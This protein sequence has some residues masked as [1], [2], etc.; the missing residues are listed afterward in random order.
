LEGKNN[1]TEINH[2]VRLAARVPEKQFAT[3]SPRIAP[4]RL[5]AAVH[6]IHS[7]QEKIMQEAL[8]C[9]WARE[10][11]LPV[12]IRRSLRELNHRFLDLSCAHARTPL[13][14]TQAVLPGEVGG[15]VASLS[16]AQRSA[17]ANCPYA[18]FDLRFQ[19]DGHW[20]PRVKDAAILRVADEPGI[21][22]GPGPADMHGIAAGPGPAD[23]HGIAAGPGVADQSGIDATQAEFVRLAL[24]YAWHVASTAKLSAQL[25]LGMN[26]RTAALFGRITLNRLQE[27]AATEAVHLTP[28]W[29]HCG[30]YWHALVDAASR[31]DARHL[32]RVQLHGI[33]LA[34]AA[35]LPCT[36][37]RS[38]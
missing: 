6:D 3:Y 31:Q 28:R 10:I 20:G 4:R 25:I 17:A 13:E 16:P 36:P 29:S 9:G 33:Q 32:R 8:A 19:D 1:L 5:K 2:K 35:Q 38:A 12:D 37:G 7:S 18:L 15:R 23:A 30:I 34:A 26:E 21:A 27:L 22:A 11:Q 14:R 24:F